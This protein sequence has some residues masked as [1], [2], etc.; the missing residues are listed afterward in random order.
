MMINVYSHRRNVQ[1]E[2]YIILLVSNQDFIKK[3]VG[4][5]SFFFKSTQ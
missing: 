3:M 2:Y 5:R 4:T 1:G